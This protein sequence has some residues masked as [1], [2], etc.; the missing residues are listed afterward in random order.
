MKRILRAAFVAVILVCFFMFLKTT[1]VGAS[2]R[3]I[4]QLGFYSAFIPLITFLAGM[5]GAWGW[6]YCIGSAAKPSLMRLFMIRQTGNTV[7]MFNPSG[8]IAGEL[9]NARMLVGDDMEGRD[10]YQS[11]LLMHGLMILSQLVL[12][13]VVLVRYMFFHPDGWSSGMRLTVSICLPALL[14][15]VAGLALLLLGKR[16]ETEGVKKR[17]KVI[18]LI[19]GMRFLLA[20]HIRIHPARTATAFLLFSAQWVLGSLELFFIL[21]FLHHPVD[22]WDSL[23]LDT[24][25]IILKSSA[26]FIPGQLGVEELAN[27]FTL[28]LLGIPSSGLWLPVS[29]LRRVRQLF[30]SGMSLLFYIQLKNGRKS[31]EKQMSTGD[32]ARES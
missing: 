3:L 2:L 17:H 31:G 7:T 8:A 27:K 5:A 6:K 12:F 18:T 25:I 28:R 11:V 21:N 32:V 10:A 4:G 24:L 9:F 29:I 15:S 30:W 16:K 22:V 13:I 14:L 26:A 20:A 23:F 19:D 1:D